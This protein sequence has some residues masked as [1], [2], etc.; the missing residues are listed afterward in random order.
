MNKQGIGVN[1]E[2]IMKD[3]SKHKK[4]QKKLNRKKS[5]FRIKL[6]KANIK[7]NKNI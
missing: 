5:D 7:E 6:Q 4:L 1:K 3:T 2:N